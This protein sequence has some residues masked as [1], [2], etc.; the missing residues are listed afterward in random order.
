MCEVACG[1]RCDHM[2]GET[3]IDVFVSAMAHVRYSLVRAMYTCVKTMLDSTTL[4][5]LTYQIRSMLLTTNAVLKA[6]PW[7]LNLVDNN[8]ELLH[9]STKHDY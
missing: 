4:L 7:Y 8:S 5:N 9:Q 1:I 6:S 2:C 3:R